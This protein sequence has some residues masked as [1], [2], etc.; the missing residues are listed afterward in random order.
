MYEQCC[1]RINNCMSEIESKQLGVLYFVIV[2]VM[3]QAN[4]TK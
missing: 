3:E 2:V 4:R 1:A